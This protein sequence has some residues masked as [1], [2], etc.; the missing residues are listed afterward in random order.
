MTINPTA[1]ERIRVAFLITELN[2]GG[3]ERCLTQLAIGLDRTRFEPLVISI[4]PRPTGEQL[5]LVDRLEAAEIPVHFLNAASKWRLL[6]AVRR[7]R[8]T[9]DAF[10]PHVVQS[11]LFH[12]DVLASL[13]RRRRR[14]RL[15]LGLR[16]AD[17]SVWRQRL[18]RWAAQQATA[19]VCVSQAVRDDARNAGLPANKLVVIPN[20]IDVPKQR[21]AKP[22]NVTTMGIDPAR[23]LMLCVGRL[24]PQKGIDWLLSTLP[25]VF[26]RLPAHD[27]VIVGA[28]PEDVRLRAQAAK[29]DI[30]HR[31]H[32]IG[33]RRDVAQLMST[34]SLFVLT[35]RWEGMPNVVLEAM[36]AGL[37]IV[38]TKTHGVREL[39]GSAHAEQTVDFADSTALVERLVALGQ[40]DQLSRRL[41]DA[42]Q[43]RATTE[44]SLDGMVAAYASLYESHLAGGNSSEA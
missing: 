5:A 25:V 28:G 21:Q 4:A 30:T 9:L 32:F 14:W 44:F 18:E 43:A 10:R 20:A 36:A 27:L 15:F 39:I 11:F 29:L 8:R 38:A 3:A 12:A 19:V 26:E 6:N 35:S 22:L 41:G 23:R 13:A 31:V 1:G 34:A 16:V 24:H 17:P 40:D 2:V 37:P 7:L 33:W 42:N